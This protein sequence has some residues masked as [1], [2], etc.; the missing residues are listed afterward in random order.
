MIVRLSDF[1]S[2]EYASLIG[3]GSFEPEEENPMIGYR[4]AGRYHSDR[5]A[6]CF[7]L[8]CAAMKAV[9]ETMGLDN[10]ALMVPFVRTVR[11]G[12]DVL[13]LLERH[14]LRRGDNGLKVYMMCEI[15]SNPLLADEFLRHFDGFSIGSNDLT[16]LTLGVDRDSGIVT[17]VFDERN[18]AVTR[19]VASV[20]RD[21]RAAGRK[22]GLC[23]PAPS[24]YPE[25]AEFLVR[26]GIDSLSLNPDA[27]LK[28]TRAVVELER[29]L[30]R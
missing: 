30:G 3:G 15:P 28:T 12:A 6:P 17:P 13:A 20:I 14:G 25:F 10:V 2:N 11:E 26:E 9:R 23:G 18:D 4:G 19:M 27:V 16:Q 24:D 22:I 1:K 5:F 29:K 7:E 8:E 21:A